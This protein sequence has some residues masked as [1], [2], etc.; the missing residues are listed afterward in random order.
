MTSAEVREALT[1][2]VTSIYMPFTRDGEIDE[3]A[4]RGMIERDIANGSPTIILTAGDSVFD[5][6]SGDEIEWVTRVTV[7]QVAGRAMVIAAD[8]SWWLGRELEWAR[9]V[10]EIGA[11]LLMAK[12]P[13][14]VSRPEDYAE[15]YAA[16]G[17][18]IPVMIVTNVFAAHDLK[19][20]EQTMELVLERAPGVVALKDDLIGEFITRI[21]PMVHDSWA[22]ISGG[23]MKNHLF[24]HP[25]GCDGYMDVF[26]L[27][28]PEISDAY[29]S[30][31][32]DGDMDRARAIVDRH[33]RPFFD[34]VCSVTGGFRAG[35]H[36]ALEICGIAQRYHRRP[37]YSLSDEE[38]AQLRGR[39]E[40]IGLGQ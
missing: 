11:D 40:E 33:D 16:L 14:G 20:S 30:A 34:A 8:G 38:L 39:L 12:P 10:Q 22:V 5:L 19:F 6:L 26:K 21:A 28:Q 35:M 31:I 4:L 18:E 2:P 9:R 13:E 15:Y 32:E 3:G 36:A 27:L 17:D 29:W 23:Q 37:L 1:G 24:T 7:E 25:Y